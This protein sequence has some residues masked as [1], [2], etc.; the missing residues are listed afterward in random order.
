ME[1]DVKA[2]ERNYAR[3]VARSM[4]KQR[5]RDNRQKD[6]G[7]MPTRKGAATKI[8]SGRRK[9]AEAAGRKKQG[10][11]KCPKKTGAHYAEQYAGNAR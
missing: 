5:G 7:R 8:E 4:A 11:A 3:S 2:A 6:V 9:G 1:D 10:K